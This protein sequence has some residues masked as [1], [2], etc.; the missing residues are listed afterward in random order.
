MLEFRSV[1][2]GYR[3]KRVLKDVSFRL[4]RNRVTAVLGPNGSGKSTLINCVNIQA[5]R[6]SGRILL[7]GRDILNIHPS[8]RA[9]IVSILPQRLPV[10]DVTVENMVAY[11]RTPYAGWQKK[12]SLRDTEQITAAMT[13]TDT[14]KFRSRNVRDL[15]GG[16]R[17]RVFF[18]MTL[19]QDTPLILMDE[20]TTY[21]DM[22]YRTTF[23]RQLSVLKNMRKTVGIVLHDISAALRY[24]DQVLLLDGGEVAF[25]GSAGECVD[26]DLIEKTF[27]VR[28]HTEADDGNQF[29]IFE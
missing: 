7:D 19:A 26:S 10:P 22:A 18:A 29:I 27:R 16:E 9:K 15:S 5:V 4:E 11:A 24:C 2:A 20:P 1:T 25:S 14:E 3:G 21:M 12:L 23:L 13:M 6:F 17:Q 8:D 28:R